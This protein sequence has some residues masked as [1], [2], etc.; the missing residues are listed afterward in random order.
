[1]YE[2]ITQQEFRDRMDELILTTKQVV[3]YSIDMVYPLLENGLEKEA[4][5]FLYGAGSLPDS[6]MIL[7]NNIDIRAKDELISP[8][9][10]L[11]YFMNEFGMPSKTSPEEYN[12]IIQGM[13]LPLDE[14]EVPYEDIKDNPDNEKMFG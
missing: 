9:T 6:L 2:K 3:L 12:F 11:V 8:D 14:I 13:G 5:P 4:L 1:M 10:D 7:H